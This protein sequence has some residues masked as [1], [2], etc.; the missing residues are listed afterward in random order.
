MSQDRVVARVTGAKEL[1]ASLKKAGADMKDLSA[2]HKAASTIVAKRAVPTVPRLSGALAASV[3]PSGTQTMARV[4]AGGAR[5][6]Y[7]NPIH[8]GWPDRNIVPSLFLTTPAAESE[9]E[10]T[11]AY[12]DRLTEIVDRIRGAE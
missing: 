5:V 1:R 2:A 8:W 4:M 10:W 12:F 7:G 3:R 9:P 11:E 6:P